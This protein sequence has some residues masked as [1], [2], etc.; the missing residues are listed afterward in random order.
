MFDLTP[1]QEQLVQTARK[2]AK[3][4]IIPVAAELDRKHE[5]PTKLCA[6]AFELG[7]M[8]AEVPAEY[9]GTG[10]NCFDHCLMLEELN[11]ACT[12]VGTTITA[13]NLAAMPIM[14]AGTEEQK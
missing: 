1:E 12:G 5:F 11:Y 8:N 4:R 9:G 6:E 2:F 14:I 13:N 3:D 7:L 10:L